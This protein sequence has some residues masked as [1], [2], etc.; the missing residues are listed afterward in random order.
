[1]SEELQTPLVERL[2]EPDSFLFVPVHAA[3]QAL[4]VSGDW[5]ALSVGDGFVWEPPTD[6]LNP[7]AWHIIISQGYSTCFCGSPI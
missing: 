7:E 5:S 4:E 3:Q 6:N 1:M 2:K